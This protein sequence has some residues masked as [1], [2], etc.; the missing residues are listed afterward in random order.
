MVYRDCDMIPNIY[1]SIHNNYVF[2]YF[3]DYDFNLKKII[4]FALI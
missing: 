4:N 2:I 3:Y 1:S